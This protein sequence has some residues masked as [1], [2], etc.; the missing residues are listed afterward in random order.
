MSL[1][2]VQL[3]LRSIQIIDVSCLKKTADQDFSIPI[4]QKK[5][6]DDIW[7]CPIL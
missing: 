5:F 3:L 6:H 2:A 1:F 7:A 4:L